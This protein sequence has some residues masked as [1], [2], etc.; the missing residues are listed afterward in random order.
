MPGE[1]V[2][3]ERFVEVR[4]R[5]ARVV[6]ELTRQPESMPDEAAR[7]TAPATIDCKAVIDHDCGTGRR[8]P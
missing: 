4:L 7:E 2:R 1:V 3:Y 5:R 6:A 8:T